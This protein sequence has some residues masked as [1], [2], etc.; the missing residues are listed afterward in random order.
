MTELIAPNA[1]IHFTGA[2]TF[3]GAEYVHVMTELLE[4]MVDLTV[5]PLDCAANGD[6]I[7]IAWETSTSIDGERRTYMGVD[8]F[9][10]RGG[11]AIEEY[12]IFDSSVL[13]P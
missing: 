2:G 6:R 10:I 8:R 1:T 12:V 4:S 13:Q 7:C 5:T 3:S 11:M 9:L